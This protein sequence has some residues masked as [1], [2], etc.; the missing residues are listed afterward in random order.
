MI[1]IVAEVSCILLDRIASIPQL[2]IDMKQPCILSSL[3]PGGVDWPVQMV[4][5]VGMHMGECGRV[6]RGRG[7][8]GIEGYMMCIYEK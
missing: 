3:Y 4:M 1:I 7:Y 6:E 5:V 2:S 8:G